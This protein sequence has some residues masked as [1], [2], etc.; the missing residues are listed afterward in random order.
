[1]KFLI[2]GNAI[3]N[4]ASLILLVLVDAGEFPL[5]SEVN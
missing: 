3:T 1:M 2:W 4:G 5:D